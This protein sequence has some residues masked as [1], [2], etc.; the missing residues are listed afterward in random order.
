MGLSREKI[1]MIAS[2]KRVSILM[3]YKSIILMLREEEDAP[4]SGIQRWLL[5]EHNIKT[6]AENIRQFCIRNKNSKVKLVEVTQTKTNNTDGM[7]EN[8]KKEEL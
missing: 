8:F 7:F 4:F 6:S 2:R 1:D 3:P 5:D